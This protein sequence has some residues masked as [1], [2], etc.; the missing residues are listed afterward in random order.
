MAWHEYWQLSEAA[1]VVY[2]M[3]DMVFL[4]HAVHAVAFPPALYVPTAQGVQVPPERYAPPLHVT[5][6][7]V[8]VVPGPV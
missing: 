5:G 8:A 3:P 1:L 6:Q 7:F 4:V 2:T